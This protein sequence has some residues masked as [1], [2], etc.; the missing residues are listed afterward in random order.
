[1]FWNR[2]KV[3]QE[4]PICNFFTLGTFVINKHLN[5]PCKITNIVIDRM[6]KVEKVDIE[7]VDGHQYCA[8]N[9]RFNDLIT[10]FIW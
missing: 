2:N 1:M 9:V 7:G 5:I 10:E 6:G 4:S 3:L 8:Y